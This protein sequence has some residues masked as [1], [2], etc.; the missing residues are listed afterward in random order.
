MGN[1]I[2]FSF[3]WY[4]DISID[5]SYHSNT[6][7]CK[8]PLKISKQKVSS[9]IVLGSLEKQKKRLLTFYDNPPTNASTAS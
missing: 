2:K 9:L 3:H 1:L 5:K 4:V 6:A 8:I 7:N